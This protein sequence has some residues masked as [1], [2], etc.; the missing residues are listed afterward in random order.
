MTNNTVRIMKY[1][2][3]NYKNYSKCFERIYIQ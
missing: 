1:M 2:P 3:H